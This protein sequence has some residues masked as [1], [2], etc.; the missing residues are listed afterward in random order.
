MS[1]CSLRHSHE[2][3]QRPGVLA[4]SNLFVP[5]LAS[6]TLSASPAFALLAAT[7]FWDTLRIER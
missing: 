6:S 1:I 3:S 2:T 4:L 7:Q 5:A